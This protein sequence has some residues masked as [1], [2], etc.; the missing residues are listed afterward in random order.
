MLSFL[1]IPNAYAT[2]T[3]TGGFKNCLTDI[4]SPTGTK[5][6]DTGLISQIIGTFLPAVIAVGGMLTI[7]FIIISGIQFIT[8]GGDPKGAAAAKD[9]LVYAVIGFVLLILAFAILQI[10]D[11]I[12]LRSGI[13]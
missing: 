10:V 4:Q 9:K 8:S 11:R 3:P 6:T 7:I 12:L 1:Q 13:V 5:F 2:C